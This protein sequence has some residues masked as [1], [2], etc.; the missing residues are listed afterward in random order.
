MANCQLVE[1]FAVLTAFL[2]TG[3][4]VLGAW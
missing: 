4:A 3:A 2:V 1:L